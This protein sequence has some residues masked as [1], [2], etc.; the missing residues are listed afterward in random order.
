MEA[1]ALNLMEDEI[2]AVLLGDDSQFQAGAKVTLLVRFWKYQLVQ[3]Y[4]AV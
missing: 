3:N 2:G 1:F 4:L